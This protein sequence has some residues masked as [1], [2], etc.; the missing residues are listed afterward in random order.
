MQ[1]LDLETDEIDISEV[2]DYEYYITLSDISLEKNE[3]F[4]NSFDHH[5]CEP[6]PPYAI[7]S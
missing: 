2:F 4:Y 1:D 6:E 3:G 7:K 5:N